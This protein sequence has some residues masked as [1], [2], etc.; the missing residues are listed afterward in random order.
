MKGRPLYAVQIAAIAAAYFVAARLGFTLAYVAEQVTT[1]WPPAGIALAAVLIWGYRVW[2]GILA[3]G[4]RVP[5]H[6]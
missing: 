5:P 1:V 2:P 4:N 3:G 6:P